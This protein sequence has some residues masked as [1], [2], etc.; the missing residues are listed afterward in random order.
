VG[1]G[2]SKKIGNRWYNLGKVMS[3][4]VGS[5]EINLCGVKNEKEPDER[6]RGRKP[7]KERKK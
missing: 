2:R 6:K 4:W 1:K 5:T 3:L 7:R